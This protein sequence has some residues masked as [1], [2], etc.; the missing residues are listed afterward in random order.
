[1]ISGGAHY[2]QNSIHSQ[3]K[4]TTTA[5]LPKKRYIINRRRFPPLLLISSIAASFLSDL[6]DHQDHHAFKK[7]DISSIAI[8]D[9]INCRFF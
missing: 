3:V 2:F 7:K 9:I 4:T 5:T 1:L 8:F 6:Q